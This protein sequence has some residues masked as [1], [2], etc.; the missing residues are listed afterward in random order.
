MLLPRPAG[1]LRGGGHFEPHQII[2]S[3]VGL[4]QRRRVFH[5]ASLPLPT[6]HSA[7]TLFG[8]VMTMAHDLIR[9]PEPGMFHTSW[10]TAMGYPGPRWND[11][12]I[13]IRSVDD[14]SADRGESAYTR[15]FGFCG[16]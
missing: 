7:T 15:I 8:S 2:S 14:D 6:M 1:A 16:N 10:I 12:Q 13:V 5:V 9:S 4:H 3:L 11:A